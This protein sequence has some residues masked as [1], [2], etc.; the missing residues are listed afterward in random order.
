MNTKNIILIVLGLLIVGGGT[1]FFMYKGGASS[2]TPEQVSGPTSLTALMALGVPQ[3]CDFADTSNAQAQTSGTVY[4]S[5]GKSR[6]DFTSTAGG[7]TFHAHSIVANDTM[8][9]WVDENG[10]GVKIAINKDQPK[11][12]SDGKQFDASKMMDYHCSAWIP[13]PSK[14]DVPTNIKF[15]E[16][17]APA[18]PS[19]G[20]GA[21]AGAGA[22]GNVPTNACSACDSVPEA[23]RAQCKIAAHC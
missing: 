9:S 4:V 16:M 12:A 17:T 8:Y 14:F 7:Q 11:P 1:Y 21:S 3:K 18:M 13:D 2:S 6:G 23:Y 20:G 10:I 15:M 19:A 22:S 5:G